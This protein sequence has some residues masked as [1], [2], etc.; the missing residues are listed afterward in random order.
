M[1]ELLK[2]SEVFGSDLGT[3]QGFEAKIIVELTA[4]PKFH[5]ARGFLYFY[6]LIEL[7]N[8]EWASPIIAALKQ[9]VRICGGCKQTVNPVAK[10][11][12]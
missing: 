8:L 4:T 11:D 2:Y 1:S 10:M 5:I 3:A 7:K 9:E 12:R 6:R